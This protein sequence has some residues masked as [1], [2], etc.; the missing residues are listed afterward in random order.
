M[1]DKSSSGME[2]CHRCEERPAEVFPRSS[3]PPL[4]QQCVRDIR[5]ESAKEGERGKGQRTACEERALKRGE[6]CGSGWPL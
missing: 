2:R 4:C 3:D 5:R 6:R 1:S